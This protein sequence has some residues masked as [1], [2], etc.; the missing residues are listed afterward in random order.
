M[1]SS[2][3]IKPHSDQLYSTLLNLTPL[4]LSLSKAPRRTCVWK[5]SEWEV[6]VARS[7]RQ[8]QAERR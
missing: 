1:L 4:S 7:L 5:L 8:A 3:G 6:A 2:M